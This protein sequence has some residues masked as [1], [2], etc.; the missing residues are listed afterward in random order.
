M[1]LT[2]LSDAYNFLN[3]DNEV[4]ML[5]ESAS[6]VGNPLITI[7]NGTFIKVSNS[8]NKMTVFIKPIHPTGSEIEV[9]GSIRCII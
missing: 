4:C 3:M 2:T 1:K 8:G 9:D 5:I 7:N 6:A